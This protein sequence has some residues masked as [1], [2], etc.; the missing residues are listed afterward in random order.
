MI[1][2]G[3][4]IYFA[5]IGCVLVLPDSPPTALGHNRG[6]GSANVRRA[7]TPGSSPAYLECYLFSFFCDV[8]ARCDRPRRVAKATARFI[9]EEL[10]AAPRRSTRSG[11]RNV[12]GNFLR[13]NGDVLL[14]TQYGVHLWGFCPDKK[15]VQLLVRMLLK[16]FCTVS[17]ILC[18]PW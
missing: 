3:G 12:F 14:V 16:R 4:M 1:W 6:I 2:H 8:T 15:V 9:L 13:E 5:C 17:R 7:L 10:A 18:S 11:E